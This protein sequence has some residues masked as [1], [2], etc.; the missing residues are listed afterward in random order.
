MS[1]NKFLRTTRSVADVVDGMLSSG[2]KLSSVQIVPFMI[3]DGF[4]RA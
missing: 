1:E 3:W 4:T 2:Y